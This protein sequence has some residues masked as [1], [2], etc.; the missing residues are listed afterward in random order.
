MRG[1]WTE[2][3][4]N[5]VIEVS[6]GNPGALRVID[7]LLWF[8]DWYKMMTWCK[9]NDLCVPNLWIKYK[10]EFHCDSFKL[11]NWIN[12]QRYRKNNLTTL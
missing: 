5:L 4:K 1:V 12:K 2:D 11:G 3:T 9:E 7:E 8:S 10:D 6:Q